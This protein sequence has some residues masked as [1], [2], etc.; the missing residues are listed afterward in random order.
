[1][2][3]R[4]SL[5]T[6]GSRYLLQ[7]NAP[8]LDAA[9]AHCHIT[10]A[11]VTYL[12]DGFNLVDPKYSSEQRVTDVGKGWHGLHLYANENWAEHLLKYVD[13]LE[14]LEGR[15]ISMS[16]L[17]QL[18]RLCSVQSSLLKDAERRADARAGHNML[19]PDP[20]TEHLRAHEGTW[21]L[22]MRLLA[23]RQSRKLQQRESGLGKLPCILLLPSTSAL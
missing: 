11:C 10:F 8:F 15:N 21:S 1:M 4:R 14:G 16:L 2:G 6:D 9:T 3:D 12:I 23:Y 19:S 5:R 13:A 17:A 22:V 7:S 20:R 18:S